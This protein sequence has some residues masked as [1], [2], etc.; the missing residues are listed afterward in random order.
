L[1]SVGFPNF[2]VAKRDHHHLPPPPAGCSNKFHFF[3]IR[4][5]IVEDSWSNADCNRF[6]YTTVCGG[7]TE[8]DPEDV[9]DLRSSCGQTCIAS[10]R[11]HGRNRCDNRRE[12]HTFNY[13]LTEY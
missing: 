6:T 2:A 5:R 10:R 4:D 1:F 11:V 12:S 13:K 7:V 3:N 9:E 8:V